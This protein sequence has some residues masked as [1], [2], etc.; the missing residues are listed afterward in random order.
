MNEV[1]QWC[2]EAHIPCIAKTDG[3]FYQGPAVLD[4]LHLL[5]AVLY[6]ADARYL[7]NYLMS[8]YSGIRPS[9]DEISNRSGK[10]QEILDYLNGLAKQ[11]NWKNRVCQEFCVNRFN[12]QHRIAA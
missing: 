2:R 9:A 5:G 4:V 8:S 7:F 11:N 6:S 10:E 3:G 12:K 1:A